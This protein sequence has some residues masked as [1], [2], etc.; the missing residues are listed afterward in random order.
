MV[1]KTSDGPV[2]YHVLLTQYRA[3]DGYVAYAQS[4]CW[5]EGEVSIGADKCKCALY[6]YNANGVFNDIAMDFASTDRIRLYLSPETR[7][8]FPGKY[9]EVNGAYY[10]PE[11]ARD[12]AYVKFEPI[13]QPELGMVL[14]P[15]HIQEFALGGEP[16]IIYCKNDGK[17]IPAPV[18]RYRLYKWT[19]KVKDDSG[20][21]WRIT[22]AES[23]MNTTIEV[24]CR[25]G[26]CTRRRPAGQGA[27]RHEQVRRWQ[28]LL[29]HR[30]HRPHGRSE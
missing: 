16:G 25:Y 12:G 9:L 28:L 6:D 15:S 23:P 11:V 19:S 18:G 2:T 1:F 8:Y 21:D 17:P 22:G 10:H 4:A 27:T 14:C 3:G 5:Y 30:P 7:T 26:G 24:R 20:V 13:A 29:H